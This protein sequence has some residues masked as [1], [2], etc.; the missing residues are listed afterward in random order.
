MLAGVRGGTSAPGRRRT[1]P[2]GIKIYCVFAGLGTILSMFSATALI[3]AS[4]WV[5]ILGWLLLAESVL[6]LFVLVGL[7]TMRS[8][9]WRVAVFLLG[10]N[11]AFS[12]LL[13]DLLGAAVGLVL[14]IYLYTQRPKYTQ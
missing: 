14:L 13:F 10:I 2:L 8:W 6:F 3:S 1:A 5:G 7:L 11:V 12:M 9:A 4:G